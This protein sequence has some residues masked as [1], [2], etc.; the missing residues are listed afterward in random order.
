MDIITLSCHC[1]SLCSYKEFS[2]PADELCGHICR[3]DSHDIIFSLEL[4]FHIV[5]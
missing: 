5:V 2:D 1:Q 4:M 3:W